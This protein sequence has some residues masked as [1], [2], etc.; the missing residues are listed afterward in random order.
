MFDDDRSRTTSVGADGA[1]GGA[2]SG[3][4]S[5]VAVQIH[6][7]KMSVLALQPSAVVDH[8]ILLPDE[9]QLASLLQG[10]DR[11]IGGSRRVD[12]PEITRLLSTSGEFVSKAG[13]PAACRH[14]FR[15]RSYLF[16]TRE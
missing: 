11:E 10:D 14:R 9:A 2:R 4:F 1:H 6:S 15:S 13:V 8:L 12:L 5:C 3:A 16:Y 7:S